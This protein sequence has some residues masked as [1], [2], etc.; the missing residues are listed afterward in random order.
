MQKSLQILVA[1]HTQTSL[2]HTQQLQ[3]LLSVE[4]V[5]VFFKLRIGMEPFVS[6]RL[7]LQ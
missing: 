6:F 2:L 1:K 7:L 4:D 5:E 3:T